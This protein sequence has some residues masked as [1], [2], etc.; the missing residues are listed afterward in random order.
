MPASPEPETSRPL[1]VTY[2][3]PNLQLR[4][5][6]ESCENVSTILVLD[7]TLIDWGKFQA[8]KVPIQNPEP[9]TSRPLSATYLRPNLQLRSA[10]ESCENVSTILVLDGDPLI[11]WGIVPGLQSSNSE[12]N[13][14]IVH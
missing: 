13:T 8:C 4:S 7:G 6:R 12:L 14:R 1:S 11:D 10:R 5:A 9:E 2:L 3:R